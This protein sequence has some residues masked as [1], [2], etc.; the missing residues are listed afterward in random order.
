MARALAARP[1]RGAGAVN[2][3][4]AEQGLLVA[5]GLIDSATAAWLYDLLLLRVWRGEAQHDDQV[6]DAF[7]FW[8]D[9]TLDSLLVRMAGPLGRLADR[10]LLPTY[11]YARVYRLGDE[12]PRH[13]DRAACQVAA[14]IHL[15]SSGKPP[16]PIRFAPA[17]SV[18][19]Q[20]GDAVVYLGD[21]VEHWR[22]PFA[23]EAFGQLFLNYV[24]ADGD[25]ARL[26][27]DQRKGAFPNGWLER[28]LAS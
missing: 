4:L 21:K 9:A 24:F 19:Q 2:R 6:P 16:P 5:R 17:V 1:S 10:P 14:T 20:P 8:G 11:A 13:S 28:R 25:R 12:L 23:G 26:V 27:F 7:S 15:G 3:Q 22:E 18:D